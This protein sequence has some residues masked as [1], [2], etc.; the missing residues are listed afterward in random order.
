MPVPPGDATG[1]A[2]PMVTVVDSTGERTPDETTRVPRHK[3]HR[4]TARMT[5]AK[6][7][8]PEYLRHI[9]HLARKLVAAAADEGWLTYGED[10]AGLTPLQQVISE[11]DGEIRHYHFDGDGCFDDSELPFMKLAGTVVLRP[12]VVP[13]GMEGTYPEL[14]ARLGVDARPE[15]W[16]IWNTW[17]A[18][19]QPISIIMVDLDGS[20][21]P[22]AGRRCRCRARPYRRAASAGWTYRH[23]SLRSGRSGAQGRR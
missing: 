16:A 2:V 3:P 23:R 9:E 5:P 20:R 4:Q 19:G 12:D 7:S 21:D 13:L 18:D 22:G 17:A 10:A 1:T 6:L 15:G 8:E 11:I 14:C